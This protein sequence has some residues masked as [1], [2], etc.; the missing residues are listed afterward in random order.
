MAAISTKETGAHDVDTSVDRAT[1]NPTQVRITLAIIVGG[2]PAIFDTTIVTVALQSLARDLNV[3]LPTIQWVTT[4]YLLALA[5]AIPT[6]AWAELRF[7]SMQVW[8][9]G[10]LLFMLGS[11]AC[12]LAWDAQSLIAFRAL[13]GFGAG[14]CMPLM[15]SILMREARGKNV[16][17]LTALVSLPIAIGPILGPVIGGAIL[18]VGD[19]R[20]LFLVNVPLCLVGIFLAFLWLRREKLSGPRPFDIWGF[21]VLAPGLVGIL[22]GLSNWS[23]DG[24]G[25]VDV[26]V[27]LAL[28]VMLVATFAVH[29]TRRGKVALVN[30]RLLRSRTLALSVVVLFVTGA[31]LFGAMLLLPLYWQKLRGTDALGAGLLLIPQGIGMLVIRTVAGRCTDRFGPRWV[32]VAGFAVAIIGTVPFLWADAGTSEVLLCAA[33]F[34]RGLGMGPIFITLMAAAYIGLPRTDVADASIITRISQQIG[35]ALGTAILA[36]ALESAVASTGDPVQAF[37]IAFA[38]AIGMTVVG[39]F[40]ALFLPARPGVV[41]E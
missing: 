11:I 8:I 6:V 2:L 20:W 25:Q 15:Q 13:Q 23:G 39:L 7:G 10:I 31:V 37:H 34:V 32:A 16:G 29:A 30:V 21:V 22:L 28:G 27:P 26:W 12:A 5:V 24:F 36:V 19:W 35:A 1:L 14:I 38:L 41:E 4:A 33:L 3:G 9:G 40:A 18:A 17:A